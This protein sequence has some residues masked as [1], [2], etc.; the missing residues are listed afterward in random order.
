MAQTGLGASK[1][2]PIYIYTVSKNVLSFRYTTF[3][4]PHFKML[5][6]GN[7]FYP[8]DM[9]PVWTVVSVNEKC[10]YINLEVFLRDFPE[11]IV[12]GGGS[13]GT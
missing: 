13:E 3:V 11:M 7:A 8:S 10:S 1:L 5:A 4:T 9:P 2:K 12:W 6:Q